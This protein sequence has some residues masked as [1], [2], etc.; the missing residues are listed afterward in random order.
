MITQIVSCSSSPVRIYNTIDIP[1]SITSQ[2]HVIEKN[3]NNSENLL[4]NYNT[5]KTSLYICNARLD[6]I[7]KYIY[8]YNK[9]IEEY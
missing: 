2:I 1:S 3:N 5:Y 6:Y 7:S 9:E 8:R 4:Y